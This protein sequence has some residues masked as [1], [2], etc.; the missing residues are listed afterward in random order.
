MPETRFP[1]P[2]SGIKS[3]AV[4]RDGLPAVPVDHT[5]PM[6]VRPL[7]QARPTYRSGIAGFT[8]A[9]AATDIACL[10]PTFYGRVGHVEQ[11]TLS[12][13]AN[14]AAVIDVLVQ[15]SSNGGGGTLLNQPVA[16]L[17]ARDRA[18]T[19]AFQVLTANRTA[20]GNGI[21]G[22]RPLVASVKLPLG[23]A[24]IPPQPV[25]VRFTGPKRPMLR[26][27]T[28]W[29]VINLAGQT[30]PAGTSLNIAVEW[31]EEA[32]PPVLFA[33]DSTTSHAIALWEQFGNSGDLTALANILNAGS[34]GFRLSDALLNT[35]G[36]PFPLVGPNGVLAR[37]NGMPGVL[38]LCYGINDLRQGQVTRAE[39]IAMLD[40]AIHA[41]VNG[42]VAGSSYTSPVG[43]GTT[44]TWAA[45][46]PANPDC[47][48][49]L[50][51][52]NS[53][54][55]DGNGGNL[56]A[57]AGR[58]AGMSLAQAAQAITDDL[59]AA[60]AAFADDPRVFR[61]VQKQ[62][63]L[64]RHCATL[65]ASGRMTDILH[66][67]ARGQIL[68]ARQIVPHLWDALAAVRPEYF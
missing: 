60:Y 40:A 36:I 9:A 59:Y 66:P 12:G 29:L 57:L 6:P 62:D 65:A 19:L 50:W 39:L 14:V 51:G 11:I 28:E 47:R 20:N 68:S 8:P 42:T 15:R 26:D 61:V 31:S 35:N 48:I 2:Y 13:T 37:L 34:N 52:P 18:P 33:G 4:G 27:L 64:G 44:F 32:L 1:G 22:S 23:T 41:T 7:P 55:S 53:L 56:V 17:D 54:A 5:A 49:I 16:R 30:L 45:T 58:F 3:I 38:V 25:T 46:I 24:T 63:V 67:N 43:A 21:D 10:M